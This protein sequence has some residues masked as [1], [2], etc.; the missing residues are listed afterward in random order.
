MNH[1]RL[2]NNKNNNDN[3]NNN[4]DDNNNNSIKCSVSRINMHNVVMSR[5]FVVA[6]AKFLTA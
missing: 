3:Y 1:R 5:K 6:V 4:N 2:D